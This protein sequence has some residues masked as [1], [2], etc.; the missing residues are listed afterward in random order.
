MEKVQKLV[1]SKHNGVY[2]VLMAL[3]CGAMYHSIHVPAF[4]RGLMSP[5]SG[6]SKILRGQEKKNAYVIQGKG[7]VVPIHGIF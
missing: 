2:V 6:Q 7:R 1:A 4:G 5:L 3:G